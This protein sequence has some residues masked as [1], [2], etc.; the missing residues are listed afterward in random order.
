[1]KAIYFD[2]AATT[3]LDPEVLEAMLP[4]MKEHYGNPSSI[5]SFGRK[6]KGAIEKNRKVIAD[7]L[8]VQPTELFFT[9]GGTE[10]DNLAIRGSVEQHGIADIISSP[11]EHHAVLHTIEDLEARGTVRFHRVRVQ[12]NGHIDLDHLQELL[13]AYPGALVSLMH[14]N[15]EIGNLL[16]LEKVGNMCREKGAIFHSD[17]VQTMG[18]YRMDLSELPVDMVTCSAHK[19]HGPKGSGILYIRK[20]SEPHPIV[21]GGGQ[22]RQM[23]GGTENLY[24]IIGLAKAL[25]VA[26]RDMEDHEE[27]VRKVRNKMIDGLENAIEGVSFHG[28]P[29]GN[30]LYTVLNVDFPPIPEAD[31]LLFNLDLEGVAA[32]GGSAC[33]SGS[34][35]GSHV[36][37][38]IG[39]DPERPNARFSFSKFNRPEETDHALDTLKSLFKV[40]VGS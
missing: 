17:T 7:L 14:A 40:S 22:E 31:M 11:I 21:H 26:H 15:N 36:L 23:R 33:S 34:D 8:N 3:A 30:C 10:A 18:H 12:R 37:Q 29:K 9:S 27:Q 32:S 19:F 20:G 28:D 5:H 25:E 16:D 4:F 2:N 24:G 1:M 39:A 38:G 13:N 35:Q 6:T